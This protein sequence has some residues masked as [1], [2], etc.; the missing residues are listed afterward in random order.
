M[1]DDLSNKAPAS[2]LIR[3]LIVFIFGVAF[4]YIEAAVVVYLREIFYPAGFTFPLPHAFD[5]DPLWKRLLF[6]EVGREAATVVV[7]F[8][9]AWLF[10]T[11]RRQRFAHFLAIFAVWDIFYYVWL[12]VLLD[13]PTSIMDWD[14]LFLIPL[15][16]ASPVLA[17]LLV[18]L[19][20]LLFAWQILY[21]DCVARPIRVTPLCW[22]GFCACISVVIFSLCTVGPCITSPGYA[23]HFYWPLFLVPLLASVALFAHCL[24]RSP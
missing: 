5:T 1:S 4:G 24:V 18:S 11:N 8:T 23:A 19:V 3:L 21:R 17:P 16:W 12:K 7:I 6:T 10:G 14:I 20:M 15:P 13:W 2:L 22:F 9:A